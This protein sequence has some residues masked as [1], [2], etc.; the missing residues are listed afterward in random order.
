MMEGVTAMVQTFKKERNKAGFTLAELLLVVAIII[1]LG[2]IAFVAVITYRR[3]LKLLEMDNIAKDIFV[4]SQNHLSS[5]KALGKIDVE[6]EETFDSNE[7]VV[8]DDSY[9]VTIKVSKGIVTYTK[10]D[11]KVKDFNYYDLLLPFGSI[12]ETV[13]NNYYTILFDPVTGTVLEVFYS[14]NYD[15]ANEDYAN[16]EAVKDNK[17]ARKRYNGNGIIG[18]YGDTN[19]LN[20][21]PIL[22]SPRIVIHN[23]E[24][25][26]LEIFPSKK[27]LSDYKANPSNT[28][29]TVKYDADGVLN[30]VASFTAIYGSNASVGS[31]GQIYVVLDD[32]TT[33]SNR[34]KQYIK[35]LKDYIGK[36]LK[37]RVEITDN[38]S[39]G[40]T[41][42]S[43]QVEENSLFGTHSNDSKVAISNFRHLINL[44]NDS[45]FLGYNGTTN[46]DQEDNLDWVVFKERLKALYDFLPHDENAVS[47][48]YIPAELDYKLFYNGEKLYI[49]SVSVTTEKDAGLVGFA[50]NDMEVKDLELRNF[51]I[52]STRNN[53]GALLGKSDSLDSLVKVTNVIAYN[54]KKQKEESDLS[55]SAAGYAGGL[56][57]NI[58]KGNVLGS[59]AAVYVESSSSAGGL[60]GN[61]ESGSVKSS[62]SGAHTKQGDFLKPGEEGQGRINVKATTNAGGLIGNAG[63]KVQVETSYSVCSVAGNKSD[64]LIANGGTK[65][66]KSYGAGWKFEQDDKGRIKPVFPELEEQEAFNTNAGNNIYYSTQ[67]K[68]PAVYYDE[69]WKN[70]L[71]PYFTIY[72]L[73]S[74]QTAWFHKQHV[75]DWALPGYRADF[76]ND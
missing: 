55:I 41:A 68:P 76:I 7:A 57:G 10:N 39:F 9:L 51:N 67:M 15:V 25:L 75:G 64:T 59:A 18:Y 6:Y 33:P 24:I 72:E 56:I 12:D 61:I 30:E 38:N 66:E 44:S 49:D 74:T 27:F 23:E 2:G 20:K 45:G 71:F 16:L 42:S 1:I 48:E 11:S 62:Y 47:Y 65:D 32:V 8:T 22:P 21:R 58:T 63:S 37:I 14:D 34:T 26:Y 70:D 5:A 35:T 3:N 28:V 4:V 73:D 50:S 31:D 53:A 69:F 60:I 13:K 43:E 40:N 46:A 36:N 52:K 17:E 19:G 29:I 54:T